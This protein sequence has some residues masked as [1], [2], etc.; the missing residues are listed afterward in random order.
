MSQL[1]LNIISGIFP[2]RLKYAVIKPIFKNGNRNDMSNYR[3]ITLLP[4]LSKLFENVLNVRMYQH[5]INNN[6]LVDEEVCFQHKFVKY[7]SHF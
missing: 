6:V 5:L 7:Y 3:P 1:E 2:T 4:S